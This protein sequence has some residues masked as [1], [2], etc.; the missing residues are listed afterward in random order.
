MARNARA[1]A[2]AVAI[3][4]DAAAQTATRWMFA[5]AGLAAALALAGA[6]ALISG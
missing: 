5:A 4:Q 6:L 3:Q 1:A 2:K